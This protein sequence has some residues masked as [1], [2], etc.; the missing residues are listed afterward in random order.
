M[1]NAIEILARVVASALRRD[2][3]EE[4]EREEEG[5]HVGGAH[6]LSYTIT[7]D[8][9]HDRDGVNRL[10]DATSLGA[11]LIRTWVAPVAGTLNT[12]SSTLTSSTLVVG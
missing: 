4:H 8:A 3:R 5:H 6:D 7:G 10:P 1:R 12:L 11:R 9:R 2:A